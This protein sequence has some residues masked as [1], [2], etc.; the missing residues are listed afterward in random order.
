ML[1]LDQVSKVLTVTNGQNLTGGT[2]ELPITAPAMIGQLPG[3]TG[4]QATG[5]VSSVNAYRSPL[6]PSINT[7]ALSVDAAIL[8]L[9]AVAGTA[10]AQGSYLNW[11]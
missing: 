2:A 3:V 4:V 5:T 8:G 9:P 7:N 1:E 10:V 6:I 11:R